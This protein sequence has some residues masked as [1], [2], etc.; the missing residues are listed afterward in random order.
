MTPTLAA[1][2]PFDKVPAEGRGTVEPT[3]TP[4]S[5]EITDRVLVQR[6]QAGDPTGS[7]AC[8]TT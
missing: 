8:S 2:F 7:S 5:P 1:D 4:E 3:V 6:T